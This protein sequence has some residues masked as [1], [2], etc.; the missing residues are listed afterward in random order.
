MRDICTVAVPEDGLE[1]LAD[2]VQSMRIREDQEYEGIR[3]TLEARLG[4]AR[5]PL[6][7]DVG[8]GDVIT[9]SPEREPFPALLDFEPPQPRTYLRETVITE[10]FQA[11]VQLGIAN[12]R[13]KDFYDIWFLAR[14]FA[15]EG[16][17]LAEAIRHTFD[18]RQTPVPA[19]TPLA[20]TP[21]FARK[22]CQ[23]AAVAGL[24]AQRTPAR[25]SLHPR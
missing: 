2:T 5:V 22:A 10:K 21:A 16:V 24:P 18:R 4:A 9:P 17:R 15:F 23:A 14:S 6:Q 1:F 11:M 20:L 13:M 25:R 19:V 8:F 3:I 7:I 12:S